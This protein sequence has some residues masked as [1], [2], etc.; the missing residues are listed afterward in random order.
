MARDAGTL[1]SRSPDVAARFWTRNI[2]E[3]ATLRLGELLGDAR[4][5]SL[6]CA[7][8]CE[9]RGLCGSLAL[10]KMVCGHSFFLRLIS[11]EIGRSFLLETR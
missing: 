11:F 6:I 8:P 3:T 4:V 10:P 1:P 7:A 5:D 2:E 9:R